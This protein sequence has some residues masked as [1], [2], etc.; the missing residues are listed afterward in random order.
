MNLVEF[1]QNL[2]QQ[3]V[4]LLVEGDKLRYHAPKKTLTSTLLNQI[5]Q[6]KTEIIS[7]LRKDFYSSK[8]YP[9]SYGQQGLWFLYKLAPHSAAYNI[10]FTARIRS[11]IKISAL[12]Q[13]LQTLITR[14]PTLRAA[15][16]RRGAGPGRGGRGGRGGGGG[17]RDAA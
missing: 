13:A 5:K 4:E 17:A 16:G 10:A 9:L 12:Q 7:L 2:S 6:H 8:S 14:H 3:N 15:G 11:Q 1:L